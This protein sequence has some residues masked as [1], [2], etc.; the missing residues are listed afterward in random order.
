M[1]A[2]AF[3]A[4]L[5]KA[6]KEK[7]IPS[8]PEEAISPGEII[9]LR[10]WLHWLGYLTRDNAKGAPDEELK[11]GIERLILERSTTSST[12]SN[13]IDLAK[14][15]REVRELVAFERDK[16]PLFLNGSDDTRKQPVTQR[17]VWLR[18]FAL[19]LTPNH[20]AEKIDEK[21]IDKGLSNF[22]KV[23][24]CIEIPSKDNRDSNLLEQLFDLDSLSQTLGKQS[25][26][27]VF[28]IPSSWS[29][30]QKREAKQLLKNFVAGVARVELWLRGYNTGIATR[31][32]TTIDLT[33]SPTLKV[34]LEKFW[35][36]QPK[37]KRPPIHNRS[38]LSP[39]IFR[40]F[41]EKPEEPA[42]RELN[43]SI[44][45]SIEEALQNRKA[46]KTLKKQYRSL[47]H[48]VW[49]GLKRLVSWTI[50][51]LR[52]AANSLFQKF[53]NLAR[54]I[55]SGIQKAHSFIGH[56]IKGLSYGLGF[57]FKRFVKGSHADFAIIHHDIEFDMNILVNE[58]SDKRYLRFLTGNLA[59]LADLLACSLFFLRELVKLF[60]RIAKRSATA[61][62]W[63]GA[64]L[65]I[66]RLKGLID[67]SRTLAQKSKLLETR[68]KETESI[69][70][71]PRLI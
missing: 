23:A 63:L 15:H 31:H 42:S 4:S 35:L 39:N 69:F 20:P 65:A 45:L 44:D 68:F 25:K 56:V 21:A 59:I 24:I 48:I 19:G 46:I 11:S 14:T 40:N 57:F 34:A 43:I 55:K 41:N 66:Y 67:S 16:T 38:K 22:C 26:N 50:R 53:R 3:D 49:D 70:Q 30:K 28:N 13:P 10:R 7:L 51:L 47:I 5:E 58:S 52:R 18:L 54:L 37:S 60:I 32:T 9:T 2:A 33:R 6:I 1:N 61:L 36:D 27:F 8:S 62:G 17:A 29:A 64:V 71:I 12:N